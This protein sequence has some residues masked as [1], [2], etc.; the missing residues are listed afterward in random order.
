MN[1]SHISSWFEGIAPVVHVK[2]IKDKVKQTPVGYGFVEFKDANTAQEIFET[3][4]GKPNLKRP[5][6]N[7][8]LNRASHGGGIARVNQQSNNN[9]QNN[10]H[11]YGGGGG[12]HMGQQEF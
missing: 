6:K 10:N 7:Y 5:D 8:K 9:N 4:N 3:L 12:H 1:E 11:N 2:L